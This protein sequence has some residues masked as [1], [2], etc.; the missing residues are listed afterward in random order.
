MWNSLLANARSQPLYDWKIQLPGID[1]EQFRIKYL[2]PAPGNAMRLLCPDTDN[3]P[4]NCNYRIVRELSSG[5]KACCPMDI[6]RPRIPI[7][8][9]EIGIYRLNYDRLHKEIADALGIEFSSV[10]LDDAFFWELGC[11]KTGTGCRMPVYISYYNNMVVFEHQ[12]KELLRED[13]VFILFV[14]KLVNVPKLMLAALQK[15]KS[16][17]L[18]LD[19]CMTINVN[20]SLTADAETINLLNSFHPARQPKVLTEY[21]CAPDTR[22]ADVHIRKKD[23]DNVSIWVKG[24]A[25]IQIN[26]MQLGMCNQKKGCRTEAFTALLALLSMP[27]KVLPLPARD[28]REYDFWKHRKYE[29]CA[30]LRK[31]F[32]NINDGDPIEFV[33]N[34]GYQVR[35]VNRDDASGSSNYHPSRT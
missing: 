26:Y 10:D 21:Q 1:I 24:E 22:W 9:E 18:G 33:K 19:D 5:L 29:I 15:K 4:E 20:G 8:P 11:L 35:F 28:T 6:T 30:A 25:P 23:G 2:N 7:M 16:V 17:C 27:G 31:F 13:R 14:G 3:C 34:E 32:P 12:L